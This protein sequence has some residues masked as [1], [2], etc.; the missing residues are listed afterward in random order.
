MEKLWNQEEPEI[1]VRALG[2]VIPRAIN[3]CLQFQR[4]HHDTLNLTVTTGTVNLIGV[5]VMYIKIFF[6]LEVVAIFRE[7]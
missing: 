1:V 5:L 3:L 6:N 7:N 4:N 2:A